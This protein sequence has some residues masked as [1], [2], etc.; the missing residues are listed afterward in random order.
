M[1][2]RLQ[3]TRVARVSTVPFFVLTQLVTQLE[4]INHAG[5]SVTVIT[6]DDE[7]GHNLG[8]LNYCKFNP[9]YIAREIS[10]FADLVALF[11]L[12]RFFR[13]QRFDI[14]H[15]TTPKAGLLCAIAGWL[16]GVPIRLHTFTGQ[17]WITMKGP[18]KGIV[19][20]CDKL[21]TLF[22]TRCY[23]DS[24]SQRDFLV[25]NKVARQEKLAVIGSGSL[26]G[27]DINRFSQD[28]FSIEEKKEIRCSLNLSD[29]TMVLLFVGRVTKD[30][31]LYELLEVMRDLLAEG[32][33]V[34]LLIVGPFEQQFEQEIRPYAQQLC[35]NKVQFTGFSS[36]PEYF[37]AVADILCIPSYR[38]G[39]GTVVIEAAAMGIPVVGTNIYGLTDAVVNGKT[40]LLVEKKNVVELR[41]A[42]HKLV[43]DKHLRKKLGANAKQRAINEFDSK[44]CGELLVMEYERL[45]GVE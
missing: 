4:A 9:I 39:F 3:N 37:M 38:E 11:K 12:W 40:G 30:K 34:S 2:K 28:G 35:G 7:L 6:S 21:I 23:A 25:N 43:N 44:K 18:K 8:A 10:F 41:D 45:L 42:L 32:H 19:K 15:S 24:F 22:N 27:V 33:D 29:E 36:E 5:A 26:A 13:E 1:V 16:A 14:V 17:A 31:G 20:F